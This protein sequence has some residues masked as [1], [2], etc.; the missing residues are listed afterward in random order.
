[1][2][3]LGQ[4]MES[5]IA[6]GQRV[7]GYVYPHAP[8]ELIMA[9]GIFPSLLWANPSHLGS[10]EGS[11]QTFA[12]S[13][14]RN[15]FSQRITGHA[16]PYSGLLFPGN[17]CDSLENVRDVW[18]LRFPTDRILRLTYPVSNDEGSS[19]EFL[20]EELR[21]FS[22]ALE[23]KFGTPLSRD[24]LRT[25][26]ETVQMFRHSAQML[27][28]ARVVNPDVLSYGTLAEAIRRFLT[29]P[30]SASAQSLD[31]L[32]SKTKRKL[33]ASGQLSVVEHVQQ[34]LLRQDLDGIKLTERRHPVLVVAGG[35][36]EPMA[37][38][39]LV[40]SV[41]QLGDSIIALDLLSFGFRTVFA[42]ALESSDDIF[43][44]L[45]RALYQT[46][47][48]PVQEGL[49][50]RLD[51]L[52]QV[53]RSLSV[54][55][56]IVCQQSFCDPDQFEAPS[57]ERVASEVGVP[58]LRLPMDPEFSDRVRLEGRIQTFVETIV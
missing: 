44:G 26:S 25:A 19:L 8:L 32:W 28:A 52:K 54:Q 36:V 1:M 37:I 14:S 20:A 2:R 45:A 31:S 58:C 40:S 29:L 42:P 27:Y 15:L 23:S 10:F 33:S 12:C 49:P 48:E 55:G 56:L 17:T 16:G 39:E 34:A 47:S 53:L 11:L 38:A 24:L 46:P 51:F 6:S 41:P 57:L 18:R 13:L 21:L 30:V 35:M 43:L 4:E 5:L 7:L 50:G 3:V 9:H 22:V